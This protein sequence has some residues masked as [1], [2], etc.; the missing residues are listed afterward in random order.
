MKKKLAFLIFSF[1]LCT[2][3]QSFACTTFASVNGAN[4][5]TLIAKNRDEHPDIQSVAVFHPDGGYAFLGMVSQQKP[6]AALILRSGINQY[7]LAIV[8]M[9]VPNPPNGGLYG[10]G[11]A[12]IRAVLTLNRSVAE[13]MGN[14]P[15][16][17][18]TNPYPE[19]YLL[20]DRNQT[21][22]IEL[23]SQGQYF[24]TLSNGTPLYH[25]NNYE[26]PAFAANNTGDL[27]G[28]TNR[29]DRISALM[30]SNSN[31]TLNEFQLF[32]HDHAAGSNDSIFR[33]GKKVGNPYT[34]RTL[35]TF[36]A[37]IPHDGS[38][39][40]VWIQFYP[41]PDI[42]GSQNVF[43]YQLT[44]AFWNF[45]GNVKVLDSEQS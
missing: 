11:D 16:L 43:E 9:A 30:N 19:F 24:V 12:F 2:L 40:T 29:Y 1:T 45:P 14:L 31:Y 7:G 10:D 22:L 42:S 44:P 27:E 20:A 35:A 21:A 34:A 8:N 3:Q 32:A 33:T 38:A 36:I 28:S 5:S 4:Q 26:N 15:S 39:P 41:R 37:Q 23:A 17:V 13:V 6:G 25:T 18:A